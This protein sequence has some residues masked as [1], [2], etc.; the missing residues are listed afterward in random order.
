MYR[1]RQADKGTRESSAGPI[2]RVGTR[3]GHLHAHSSLNVLNQVT[4]QYVINHMVAGENR[5]ESMWP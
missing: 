5:R 4:R 1:A 2:V 3:A